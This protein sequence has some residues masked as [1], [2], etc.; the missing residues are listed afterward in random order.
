[1]MRETLSLEYGEAEHSVWFAKPARS[2]AA[3]IVKEMTKI[4]VQGGM[5]LWRSRAIMARS[6]AVVFHSTDNGAP[7]GFPRLSHEAQLVRR[8][9]A[10]MKR[11]EAE[12]VWTPNPPEGAEEVGNEEDEAE[13]EVV[14]EVTEP[15]IAEEAEKSEEEKKR[16]EKKRLRKQ[17]RQEKR[18]ITDFSL[19]GK[20]KPVATQE[21]QDLINRAY[22]RRRAERDRREEEERS[23][24]RRDR[25]IR[26]RRKR[27]LSGGTGTER[28][29]IGSDWTEAPQTRILE[30][31]QERE[32]D[33]DQEELQRSEWRIRCDEIVPK[34]KR[35]RVTAPR[36]RNRESDGNISVF[37][38]P[39]AVFVS[40][41]I[42][43]EREET[44]PPP[45]GIG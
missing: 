33:L 10:D 28:P 30:Q 24:E 5:S 2:R 25:L 26:L 15:D 11:L 27:G 42:M 37:L 8:T 35:T 1:M 16:E 18:K 22:V 3:R 17:R 41:E 43:E 31:E 6:I 36:T 14:E 32:M 19:L 45:T 12:H 21:I 7:E 20:L 29:R 23:R 40:D 44:P 13:T 38:V 39:N 4:F 34:Q 9:L